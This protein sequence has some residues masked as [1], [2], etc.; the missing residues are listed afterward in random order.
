LTKDP[1]YDSYRKGRKIRPVVERL[2]ATTGIYV[3]NGAGL[4]ELTRFQEHFKEYRIVVFAGLNC[5]D[6]M[7]D[8][9]VETEKRLNLLY[10]DVSKHY[11]VIG[12]LTGALSRKYVCKGCNKGCDS[13]VTHKCFET[14][15]D[16][17]SV[18]P[19]PYADYESRA[20]RATDSLEVARVSINTRQTNWKESPYVKRRKTVSCAINL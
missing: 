9:H 8:G 11:H 15:S 18:P 1:D 19:C 5:E 16:C 3:S 4:P 7:F 2:L 12:N 13:G 6:I 14:C 20:R 17:M 10:D